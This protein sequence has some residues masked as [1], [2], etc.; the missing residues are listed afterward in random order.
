MNT[1][2]VVRLIFVAQ[3]ELIPRPIGTSNSTRTWP[4][5]RNTRFLDPT[6]TWKPTWIRPTER[7][8]R[9]LVRFK[10]QTLLGFGQQRDYMIARVV[11]E[12]DKNSKL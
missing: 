11:I 9:F 5:A 2:C 6:Q 1:C 10:L 8:S 3:G 7:N 4:T 12:R